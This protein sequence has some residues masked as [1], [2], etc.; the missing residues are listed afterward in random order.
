M[1]WHFV[2]QLLPFALCGGLVHHKQEEG[3]Q[4]YDSQPLWDNIVADDTCT[5]AS[6]VIR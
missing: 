2:A 1:L 3:G 4:E 5:P 6:Q